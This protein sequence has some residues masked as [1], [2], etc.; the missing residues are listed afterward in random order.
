MPDRIRLITPQNESITSNLA[1]T[2]KW[3]R[4]YEELTKDDFD[5]TGTFT[6]VVTNEDDGFALQLDRDPNSTPEG[7]TAGT[8]CVPLMT[9]GTTDGVTVTDNGNL[10]SGYEGWRGFDNNSDTRWGVGAT[11]GILSITLATAKIVAG[12]SIRARN[13]SYL[14]DS[15]KAWTF[16]GSNN[17]TDWTVLDTQSGITSWSMNERKEFTVASPASYLCYRVTSAR[18]RAGRTHRFPK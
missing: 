2:A 5:E 12:Y 18:T 13:D 11:S 9:A 15:P 8:D 7:Y 17:G 1:L 3:V 14:I 4:T 16:E 6:H 10:G